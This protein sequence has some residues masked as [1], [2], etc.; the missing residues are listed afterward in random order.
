MH[1]RPRANEPTAGSAPFRV[2]D[3]ESI[4]VAGGSCGR[5]AAVGHASLSGEVAHFQAAARAPLPIRATI[6]QIAGQ[7]LPDGNKGGRRAETIGTLG[8]EGEPAVSTAEGHKQRPAQTLIQAQRW[9]RGTKIGQVERAALIDVVVVAR[10][11]CLGSRAKAHRMGGCS[12]RDHDIVAS[13][14]SVCEPFAA[15]GTGQGQGVAMAKGQKKASCCHQARKQGCRDRGLRDGTHNGLDAGRIGVVF[16][17]VF[18]PPIIA[19]RLGKG[20]RP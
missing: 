4:R 9:G 20:G 18:Q 10:Q 19:D 1:G 17:A 11:A 16:E 8:L 15:E 6:E 3:P 7:S 14:F 13:R 12:L 5:G 2:R